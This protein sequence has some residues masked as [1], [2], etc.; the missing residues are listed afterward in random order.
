MVPVWV[1]IQP[2]GH[3]GFFAK[4]SLVAYQVHNAQLPTPI[5]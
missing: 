3:F 4:L 5:L 2:R 1:L